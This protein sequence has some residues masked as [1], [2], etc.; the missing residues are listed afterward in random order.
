MHVCRILLDTVF[1]LRFLPSEVT[2][3]FLAYHSNGS[4]PLISNLI[5]SGAFSRSEFR[6]CQKRQK[7]GVG[8][9]E[10]AIHGESNDVFDYPPVFVRVRNIM[11][12]RDRNRLGNSFGRDVD[13][14]KEKKLPGQG[15]T[16]LRDGIDKFSLRF[17][18]PFSLPHPQSEHVTRKS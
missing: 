9:R 11:P 17:C 5:V 6:E 13:T 18:L 14:K 1:D 16:R 2:R 10:V 3:N 4:P 12:P 15:E 8:V 7:P